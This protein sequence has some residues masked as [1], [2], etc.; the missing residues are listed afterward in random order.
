MTT[1]V[2]RAR[3]LLPTAV[4]RRMIEHATLAPSVH[5]TQPWR[6]RISGGTIE[7]YA[8]MSRRLP[9]EDP[10]GRNLVISCGAALH[11]LQVAA[12]ALGW[13]PTVERVAGTSD[14]RLLAVVSFE[15]S[16]RTDEDALATLRRRRTDRRRFTSW[17]IP[18][19]RLRHLAA[20]AEERGCHA[21]PL[22]DE[23]ARVRLSLLVETARAAAAA[24]QARAAEQRQWVD[25]SDTDGVPS[26]LVPKD[27][28]PLRNRFGPGSLEER[29]VELEA[30][31]GIVVLGGTGDSPSAWLRTGEGL[32]ALWLK[33][34]EG[35]LSVVPLSQPIE[36]EQ[37][38]SRLRRE[39]L[40][41]L[42]LPHLV[43]RIGWQAIG[44]S[45]LPVSPRRP[46]DDVLDT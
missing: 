43:V 8:D 29:F 6:W 31:D 15:R 32:S 7:L 25:R 34:T 22:L 27:D 17:P 5:N 44:R 13:S 1:S 12:A 39:V 45:D 19:E 46:V 11:H 24:D 10:V 38:R 35:D 14:P 33:A 18:D 37:V 16:G 42:L 41:G 20:E 4:A 3:G 36:L 9:V 28:D 21:V 2:D 23:T 40:K 26:P 30:T